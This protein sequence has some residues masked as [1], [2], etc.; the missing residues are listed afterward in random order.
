MPSGL[1]HCWLNTSDADVVNLHWV[2]GSTSSVSEI[3][4]L[5]KPIVWTMHDMWPFSGAEHYESVECPG[6]S[7]STYANIDRPTNEHGVDLDAWVYKRKAL[8]WKKKSFYLV[9]PSSWLAKQAHESTLFG[10]MP[11]CIIP[12]G[13]DTQMFKPTSKQEARRGA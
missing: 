8:A 7:R 1:G 2:G 3:S 9:S 12:N 13:I 4:Y 6:R 10:R 5:K 11:S